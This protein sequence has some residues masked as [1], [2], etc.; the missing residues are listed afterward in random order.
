MIPLPDIR[1]PLDCAAFAV[2]AAVFPVIFLALTG[3]PQGLLVW[4][5]AAALVYAAHLLASLPESLPYVAK[6]PEGLEELE[7]GT[8]SLREAFGLP[9]AGPERRQWRAQR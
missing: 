2:I 6:V 8:D 7:D 3:S 1:T 4:I 9:Y 5:V